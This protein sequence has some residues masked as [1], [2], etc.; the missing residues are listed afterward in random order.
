L[1]LAIG[2][3]IAVVVDVI[4]AEACFGYELA[5]GV[6]SASAGRVALFDGVYDGVTALFDGAVVAA[7]VASAVVAVVAGLASVKGAVAAVSS[8]G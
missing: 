7:A 2:E 6:A 3:A 8:Y 1:I 4:S 5:I